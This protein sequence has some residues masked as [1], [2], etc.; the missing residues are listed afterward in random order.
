M[1]K[2]QAVHSFWSS[3]GL[4]A[5]DQN[6]VPD[7]AELPYITYST[8]TDSLDY[9]V[10]LTGSI[11]YRSTSWAEASQKAEQISEYLGIGGK[12]IPLNR[13]YLWVYRGTPFAQRMGDDT[14]ALIKRIYFN[15][16]A[17]FLTDK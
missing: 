16:S 10:L 1:D 7:G 11:W 6:S 14:D 3:F 2:A 17:E 12:V 15:V 9:V 8:A 13:G 5:Y 4:P